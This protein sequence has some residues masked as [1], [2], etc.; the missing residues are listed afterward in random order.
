MVSLIESGL[1]LAKPHKFDMAQNSLIILRQKMKRAAEAAQE[2]GR[3]ENLFL[4]F[5]A[6]SGTCPTC[7]GSEGHTAAEE[8]DQAVAGTADRLADKPY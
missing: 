4:R 6:S 5:R 2:L 1:N 8:P 7:F 3:E